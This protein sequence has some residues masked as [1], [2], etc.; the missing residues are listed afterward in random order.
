[1]NSKGKRNMQELPEYDLDSYYTNIVTRI[2]WKLKGMKV[3]SLMKRTMF[4]VRFLSLNYCMLA[5]STIDCLF[6]IVQ[7]AVK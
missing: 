4:S 7:V 6:N 2:S 3:L 1:M 5:D